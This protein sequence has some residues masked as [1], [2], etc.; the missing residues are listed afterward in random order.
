MEEVELSKFIAGGRFL[1]YAGGNMTND[2]E[3]IQQ[4]DDHQVESSRLR[5]NVPLRITSV[6]AYLCGSSAVG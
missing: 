3:E 2:D 1:E 4:L 5:F 6:P